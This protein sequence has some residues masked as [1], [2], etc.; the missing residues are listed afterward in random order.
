MEILDSSP[1]SI[2]VRAQSNS[3]LFSDTKEATPED[4]KMLAQK[5]CAQYGKNAFHVRTHIEHASS[6]VETYSCKS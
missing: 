2:T 1:D 4:V 3:P 6:R 5:H